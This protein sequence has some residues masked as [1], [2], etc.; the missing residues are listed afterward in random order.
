MSIIN[1]ICNALSA[2]FVIALFITSI[3]G[4]IFLLIFLVCL[5]QFNFSSIFNLKY[6]MLFVRA[7]IRAFQRLLSTFTLVSDLFLFFTSIYFVL[8]FLCIVNNPSY[9]SNVF[10]FE[11]MPI[12]YNVILILLYISFGITLA[13]ANSL[14][15]RLY[16]F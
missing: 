8:F 7:V 3:P 4:L 13:S 11:L 9:L 6:F 5:F 16:L 12:W 15:V 10:R 1:K 2:S 14:A